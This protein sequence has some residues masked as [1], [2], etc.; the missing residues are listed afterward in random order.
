MES[1]LD[2][3]GAFMLVVVTRKHS[4]E[5]QSLEKRSCC[6]CVVVTC[7]MNGE[8]YFLDVESHL[9]RSLFLRKK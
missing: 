6:E 3:D 7:V 8:R 2:E 9:A 5:S 4:S 1:I